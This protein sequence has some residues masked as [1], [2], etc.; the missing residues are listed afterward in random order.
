VLGGTLQA[1]RVR[2]NRAHHWFAVFT[3]AVTFLLIIAGALVTSNDAGL[4]VPDWPTSFGSL[5]RLPPMVGG[6]RFEHTHRMLAEFIGVLTI[7][8]ALWTQRIEARSWVRKLAW[9]AL[10]TVVAQGILG[11]LTV[12]YFLPPAVSTAHATLAQTFFCI[13]VVIAVVTAE[14]WTEPQARPVAET[15]GSSLRT[16]SLLAAGSVYI[17]LVLGAGFRHSGIKLLPHVISAAVVTCL[18]VWTG[19]RA[20]TRYSSIAPIRRLAM[21][22]LGLLIVQLS[23][24]FA[25]YLTRV[26]WGNNDVQPQLGM[27][28]ST[29]AHVAVGALVLATT[30]VLALQSRRTLLPATRHERSS[31]AQKAVI[32]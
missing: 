1:S 9:S 23:L 5:Y 17:Q 11:G 7:I 22:L 27:V 30:V 26:Q 12:L 13:A 28:I 29:V 15:E 2:Y 18:V 25:S 14:S 8:L 4:S 20:L 10:A 6:V 31:A 24:G 21:V 19:T 3:A 32:A 16:L